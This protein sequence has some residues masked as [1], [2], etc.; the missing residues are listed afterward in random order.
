MPKICVFADT[1]EYANNMILAIERERPDMIIHLG[2]GELDLIP[3]RMRFP[4]L[5]IENV[6]GNCDT[7]STALI[8]LQTTIHGVNIFATHGDQEQYNVKEGMDADDY[9]NLIFAAK[10]AGAGV[11][12]FGHTHKPYKDNRLMMEVLNPGSCG[13]V[14]CP[15]Y[16]VLTIH[17]G[18]PH[19]ELVYL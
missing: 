13:N 18:T 1:H 3:V 7:H 19:T 11:V 10:I 6:R 4:D 16:G 17:D 9:H 12:L 2:D 8:V 5:K 15:T 14:S